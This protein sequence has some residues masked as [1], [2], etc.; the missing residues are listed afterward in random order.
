VSSDIDFEARYVP[1]ATVAERYRMVALLGK[2]GMGEVY[3]AEDLKLGQTVALK[4]LPASVVHNEAARTRFHREVRLARQVSH[5]NVCRVFDIGEAGGRTFITME[6]VDGEDLAFLLRRIGRLPPDKALEIARQMCAG[7]AAAHDHGIIHRDLK[8]AN[9]MLDGR[10]RV[11]ITDFGLASAATDLQGDDAGAGTP[12]YMSPEQFDGREATQKSD[13]YALGLVLYEVFTGKQAFDAPTYLEMVRLREKSAPTFPSHLTKDIDPPV[14]RLILR[15]L[16]RDPAKRPASALQVAAALPGGDPLAAAL[17]A[18]E[19]PS[20]GMVA[21]AGE[22]GT[23]SPARAWALLGSVTAILI[24]VVAIA[25]YGQLVNLLPGDK[26][27]A[28]LTERAR[29]IVKS[30]GYVAPPA[31][32]AFWYQVDDAYWP[33]LSKIPAPARYRDLRGEYPAPLQFMY[34]QSPRPIVTSFPWRVDSKNPSAFYFGELAIGLDVQGRLTYFSAI[35][36]PQDDTLPAD[37]SVD[38]PSFLRGANLDPS[39]ARPIQATWY[40]DVAVD[41][42][43]A[44]DV[45]HDG[46]SIQ[47]H[48][49]SYHGGPVFFE[50]LAPWAKPSR[51]EAVNRAIASKF[52]GWTFVG[53]AVGLLLFCLVLARRNLRLGRGDKKGAL[54]VA[55]FL[56]AVQFISTTLSSH[57]SSDVWWTWRWWLATV[58]LS[59]G[60]GLQFSILYVALEP[61]IRR[62]W[63]EVLISWSRLL[64]GNLRDPLVGRDV[65]LGILFGVGM[66]AVNTLSSALPYWYAIKGRTPFTIPPSALGAVP[67]LLGYLLNNLIDVVM[68]SVGSLALILLVWRLTRSKTLAI[69][70]L[71]LVYTVVSLLGENFWFELL[72]AIVSAALVLFCLVRFGLLP[73][74]LAWFANS[75]LQ[76]API[77]SDFSR[78]YAG[79]GA[80]V[81]LIVLALTLYGFRTSL[82]GR[83]F[84]GAT[85]DD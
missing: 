18:G 48:A 21:A 32:S 57:Y 1:G 76:S 25:Q 38:W 19:T 9:V 17:A 10:G 67:M 27:P 61:Y 66:A 71:A 34:R 55:M 62:S 63:P 49:G 31:D 13:L 6:Y 12:A 82:G 30:L 85:F 44:W 46:K 23:L 37:T 54:R 78:W 28:A 64:E 40:P 14:Q 80:S 11:R 2:G 73:T 56:F 45:E 3:R 84:F 42:Q 4:F 68:N 60:I 7:L 36:L 65:L 39:K 50:V 51:V 79:W 33:Y 41:Q 24:I 35:A 53:L 16:E 8:P 47:V 22:S 75:T 70:V 59:A 74:A 83:P 81:V 43:I 29:E 20:P 77:T 69:V 58:G 5:P 52:A 15:C 72:F 26:S